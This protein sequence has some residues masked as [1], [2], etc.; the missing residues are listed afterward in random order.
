MTSATLAVAPA[1]GGEVA[2]ADD[3]QGRCL[4]CAGPTDHYFSK[5]YAPYPG[6]PF[7]QPLT[8]DYARCVHCGFVVSRTHQQ[9]SGAVWS[10][11]N[12]SWHHHYENHLDQ[13]VS[14]APP[15]A[16]QALAIAMLH[17]EGLIDAGDALDYAAGYGSLAKC[18]AR[19]FGLR[20]RLFDR[21][22][23]DGGND[24]LDEA[25]LGRYAL[26]INS[27]MFEHVLDRAALDEVNGLV[28]DGGV[29]MMHTVVCERI[30]KDPDW[31][32]LA[33]MVHTAFHT[34]RSMELLMQQWGYAASLYAPAAKS[35]FLFKRGHPALPRL[36]GAVRDINHALR[37]PFFHHKA[38][39]VDYWKGF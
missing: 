28:A 6:S 5:T 11:L 30:P 16:Q 4:I 2:A 1:H 35:W 23:H 39:F 7:P 25:E 22:V 20:A 10:A 37:A 38:G 17:R 12:S 19:Y 14:N 24:Y 26:V 33:P 27:A 18:L 9:M 13:K 29:L 15:Y 8:V 31:F 36:E 34:N 32:Y 21:Y 3:A